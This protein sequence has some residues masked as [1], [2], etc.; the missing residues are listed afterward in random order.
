MIFTPAP[1]QPACVDAATLRDGG[2]Y[3][4]RQGAGRAVAGGKFAPCFRCAGAHAA[5]APL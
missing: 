4:R 3:T 1:F 5:R 2:I